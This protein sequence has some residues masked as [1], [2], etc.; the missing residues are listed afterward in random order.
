LSAE[1]AEGAEADL[2]FEP[3]CALRVLCVET[4]RVS[5]LQGPIRFE[6]KRAKRGEKTG[7]A[8][9]GG[10]GATA[11]D[12]IQVLELTAPGAK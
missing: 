7:L 12:L 10:D 11:S 5:S 6:P 3:L 2:W 4:L 1:D 9:P 8:M